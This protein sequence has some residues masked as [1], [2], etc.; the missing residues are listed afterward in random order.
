MILKLFRYLIAI[1]LEII[2]YPLIYSLK[3]SLFFSAIM[4][5]IMLAFAYNSS[6]PIIYEKAIVMASI[7]AISGAAIPLYFFI[8]K[9]ISPFYGWLERR[10]EKKYYDKEYRLDLYKNNRRYKETGFDKRTSEQDI[11]HMIHHL[12]LNLKNH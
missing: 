2:R 12:F 3:I 7:S 8:L 4:A 1:P 10:Q 11:Y 9:S 6:N 5:I